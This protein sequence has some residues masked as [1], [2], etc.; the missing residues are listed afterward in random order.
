MTTRSDKELFNHISACTNDEQVKEKAGM[1]EDECTHV[2][3]LEEI[4]HKVT[5]DKEKEKE[6]QEKLSVQ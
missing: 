6:I 4:H 5:H 3:E 1:E 2:Y